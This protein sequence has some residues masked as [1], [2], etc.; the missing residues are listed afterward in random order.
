MSDALW[1]ALAEHW[2]IPTHLVDAVAAHHT[3]TMDATRPDL[4]TIVPLVAA[5]LALA[6]YPKLVLQRSEPTA[7]AILHI[8]PN[9]EIAVIR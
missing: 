5:I 6:L 8:N 2:S 3:P 1:T 9:P 4:A 7:D